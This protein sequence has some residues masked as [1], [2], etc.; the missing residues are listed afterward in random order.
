MAFWNRSDTL[1]T[2]VADW[3]DRGLIDGETAEA[4]RSDIQS[5]RASFSFSNIL[6][7]LAMIC[8]GFGIMTFVAANWEDMSR[9]VRLSLILGLL[10]GLWVAATA[11]RRAGWDWVGATCALLACIT[12]GGGIMLVSQMYH[13]QGAPDGA[14]FLWAVGTVF[15]AALARSTPALCLAILLWTLWALMQDGVFWGTW[16]IR[17][18]FLAA[19]ALCGA[20]SWWLRS[21]FAAHLCAIAFCLWLIP[22]AIQI[23][24]NDNLG[25]FLALTMMPFVV[26]SVLLWS[27][28]A[29]RH[30]RGFEMPGTLYA[31]IVMS[32]FVFTWHLAMREEFGGVPPFIGPPIW[33]SALGP[34]LCIAL[35]IMGWRGKNPNLYDLT[36]AAGFA[37]VT[38]ALSGF[39]G[40]MVI[41][42]EA[43]MLALSIWTIRMGW[44]QEYRPIAV[45][46]FIGF[47]C[48]MLIIYMQ[49]VGSLLGTAAFY[50]V[51]GVV[52]LAG[53]ILIPRLTRRVAQ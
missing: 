12:F 39:I 53:V 27:D 45:I 28:G 33:M 35:A 51:A 14:V 16:D 17:P 37:S 6:I 31:L 29:G 46:G 22:T 18:E 20:L 40:G 15:A 41:L 47:A 44:R 2:A 5:Q 13:M 43:L 49:T 10:W 25:L 50:L 1:Q 32:G 9:L 7:L 36:A 23:L 8:L 52:I 19:L 38:W 4:L 21:R 48:V 34:A 11:F 42:T 26:V 30:L 3:A 24:E